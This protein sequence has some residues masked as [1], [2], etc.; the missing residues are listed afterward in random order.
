[1]ANNELKVNRRFQCGILTLKCVEAKNCEGCF[2]LRICNN[3]TVTKIKEIVGNCSSVARTD[4]KSVVF[5]KV[6]K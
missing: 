3:K 2:F 1:M 4:G 6:E 5:V